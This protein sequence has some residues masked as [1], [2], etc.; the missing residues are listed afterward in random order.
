MSIDDMWDSLFGADFDSFGKRM[1]RIFSEMEKMGGSNVKTYGYT[2]CQGPDGVPYFREFGN[3]VAPAIA[4]ADEPFSDVSAEDDTVRVT[5]ELP[6]VSKEEIVLETTVNSVTV[7]ADT[8]RK[9]YFKTL[10]LPCDVDTDSAKATYNNGMLEVAFDA[11][12]EE[13]GKKRIEIE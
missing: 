3:T 8:P 6:G 12:T 13:R 5:V 11:L 9:K 4:G 1:D 10:A 2:M 7:S